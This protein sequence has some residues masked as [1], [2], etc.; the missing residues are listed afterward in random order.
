MLRGFRLPTR[1]YDHFHPEKLLSAGPGAKVYR[2]EETATGRKVLIKAL[3]ADH[4]ASH[5]YD[6]ERLQLLA[7]TLM[8]LRHPQIAGFITLLPT[9]DEFAIVSE[10]MPGM[11]ARQFAGSR[12]ITA[13]DLRAVAVQ[14]MQA[15]L[16]G[17]HLRL[18][19]GD[20]KPSNLILA[21]HP[22]GGVFLQIQDW[23]LSQARAAQP[24]ETMWFMAPERH[25]GA[26]ATSQ[27]DLFTAAASLF[28]LAT[29]TAPAQ[30]DTVE[31]TLAEWQTFNPIVLRQMRPDIDPAFGEWLGWLLKLDPAQRPGSVAQALATL[32]LSMHTGT[33]HMP[34]WQPPVMAA[35]YQTGQLMPSGT[36]PMHRGAPRPKP[37]AAKTTATAA[38]GPAT[39]KDKPVPTPPAAP[40]RSKGRLAFIIALNVVAL[41]VVVIAIMAFTGNGGAGWKKALDALYAKFGFQVSVK[42]SPVATAADAPKAASTPGAAPAKGLMARH[43]RIE[44]SKGLILNFAEVEVISGGKNI[45]PLGKAT[46]SSTEYNGKAE[47]AIDGDTNGDE[48]KGGHFSHTNGKDKNPRWDLD[49]GD[50]H[51]VEA[52]VIWNRTDEK[53]RERLKGFT[54]KLRS[55]HQSTIWEQKVDA[56]PMPSTRLEVEKP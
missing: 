15:L 5:S 45:A 38:S 49:L 50:E 4:E 34:S 9:E 36:A 26:P 13:T 20:P 21:D 8:Q 11:N 41:I 55:K 1:M 27:S 44:G 39:A 37:V 18:P 29:N 23:G 3:L 51:P 30:G 17:E 40:K 19:H 43:V 35:G 31:Q 53:W 56:P 33:I 28:V 25:S 12:Q 16:V 6:R 52:I 42:P 32:M 7:P 14:L 10:Y 2:G 54:V 47:Y 24:P 22:A 46:Q 48:S